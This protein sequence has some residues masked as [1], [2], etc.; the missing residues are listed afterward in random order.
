MDLQPDPIGQEREPQVVLVERVLMLLAGILVSAALVTRRDEHVAGLAVMAIMV[1]VLL[2]SP[3]EDEDDIARPGFRGFAGAASRGLPRG[4]LLAG[5]ALVIGQA[6][7]VLV[8][9]VAW[10]AGVAWERFA[11][12]SAAGGDPVSANERVPARLPSGG[13]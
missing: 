7:H 10:A 2:S 6:N 4:L 1:L 3:D 9:P 5:F 12:E 11:A 8:L 13:G